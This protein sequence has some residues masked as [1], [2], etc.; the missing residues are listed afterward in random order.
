LLR[1]RITPWGAALH[2]PGPEDLTLLTGEEADALV[3]GW[4]EECLTLHD[5]TRE[6]GLVLTLEV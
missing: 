6:D 5:P 1:L 3:E 2:G 4:P